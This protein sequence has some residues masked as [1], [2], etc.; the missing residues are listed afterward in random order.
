LYSIVEEGLKKIEETCQKSTEM[1]GNL[2]KKRPEMG[3]TVLKRARKE[4][5]I[6]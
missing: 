3:E 1:I 2:G 5:D 6:G 4:F